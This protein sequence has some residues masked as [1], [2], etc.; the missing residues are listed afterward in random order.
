MDEY[1]NQK[2]DCGQKIA[3]ILLLWM[4]CVGEDTYPPASQLISKDNNKYNSKCAINMI[5][6]DIPD[7][8]WKP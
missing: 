7:V 8:C 4:E 2:D 6:S 5:T 1:A 3:S